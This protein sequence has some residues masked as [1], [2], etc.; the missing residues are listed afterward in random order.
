MC[1]SLMVIVNALAY[2]EQQKIFLSTRM[3][4]IRSGSLGLKCRKKTAA[5]SSFPFPEIHLG[6]VS[7]PLL[8]R[9]TSKAALQKNLL[10]IADLEKGIGQEVV[11]DKVIDEYEA[12][13]S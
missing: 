12:S 13:Y 1:A 11:W 6:Y 4:A 5:I 3:K 8:L 2:Q 10:W 7:S 9:L